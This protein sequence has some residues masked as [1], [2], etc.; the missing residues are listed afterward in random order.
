MFTCVY[1]SG[2]SS[3]LDTYR[4]ALSKS[5]EELHVV[6]TTAGELGCYRKCECPFPSH[7]WLITVREAL[8]LMET[9]TSRPA[10][11]QG[12]PRHTALMTFHIISKALRYGSDALDP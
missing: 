5:T 9:S 12:L 4:F 1:L 8:S 3:S 11:K 10:H 2:L 6:Y 7:L